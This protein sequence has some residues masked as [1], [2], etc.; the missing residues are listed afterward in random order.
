VSSGGE[1]R[2]GLTLQYDG[3]GFFGW[4]LQK[5]ARTVQGELEAVVTRLTGGRR[6]VLGAGRT[7]RG[8]HAL[9]QVAAVTLPSSWE[10]GAFRKAANALLPDDIWVRQ[11][12]SVGSAFHPRYDAVSRTYLYHVGLSE[13]ASSPFQ[14]RW[15]WPLQKPLDRALL[16]A[17]AEPLVGDRSF[18][19]FSKSGQP[20]RGD[21]CIVHSATWSP[22][23]DLGLTFAITANRYLHHMVRYLVGTMVEVALGRRPL[24]DIRGLLERPAGRAPTSAS[25]PPQGLFL[26]RVEYPAAAWD[27]TDLAPDPGREPMTPMTFTP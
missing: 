10:P 26:E 11:V 19:A 14:K 13:E 9:G 2:L 3:A 20:E 27:S 23:L 25:A 21:R 8:V 7:D 5:E 6:P 4:Q 12:R 15:C 16:E 24:A 18:L 17:A 1:I 22:W